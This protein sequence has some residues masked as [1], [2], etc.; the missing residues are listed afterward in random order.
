MGKA[1]KHFYSCKYYHVGEVM[2]LGIIITLLIL[3]PILKYT[4]VNDKGEI[5]CGRVIVGGGGL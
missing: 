4:C 3:L 2:V 5:V 1:F